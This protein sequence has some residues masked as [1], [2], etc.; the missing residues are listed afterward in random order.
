MN[1]KSYNAEVLKRITKRLSTF[2]VHQI[3]RKDRKW[4][5]ELALP[6]LSKGMCLPEQQNNTLSASKAK[7]TW[8]TADRNQHVV[9]M[10]HRRGP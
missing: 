4:V 10:G 6:R 5:E 3:V 9:A 8:A 2:R 7:L 1:H